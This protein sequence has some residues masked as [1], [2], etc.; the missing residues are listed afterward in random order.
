MYLKSLLTYGKWGMMKK[1]EYDG[2]TKLHFKLRDGRNYLDKGYRSGNSRIS[3]M[4][5]RTDLIPLYFL[6]STGGG[7]LE[8]ESYYSETLLDDYCRAIL[9]T[10]T[11]SYIYKCENGQETTQ[12]NEITVGEDGF[13]EYYIDEVIP[14]ENS[15]FKQD[16][17]IHLK[18]GAGLILTDGITSGWSK[19]EK[20]FSYKRVKLRTRVYREDRLCFNDYL[21]FEPGKMPINELGFMEGYKNFNSLLVIDDDYNKNWIDLIYSELENEYRG[22]DSNEETSIFGISEIE[23][24]GFILR[25]MGDSLYENSKLLYRAIDFY[26]EQL[27]EL[28]PLNLRKKQY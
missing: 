8:G 24:G 4:I 6:V 7:F 28:K 26:R 9:T 5:P 15:V 14:Y 16:T 11:P 10:Q 3:A 13:L 27:K 18:K 19:D 2:I 23:E 17:K 20:L 12:L 21:V 22:T 25:I 1:E